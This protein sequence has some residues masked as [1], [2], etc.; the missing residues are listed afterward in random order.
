MLTDCAP[1]PNIPVT[2]GGKIMV[3]TSDLYFDSALIMNSSMQ[4]VNYAQKYAFLMA[5]AMKIGM[6][7]VTIYNS[8][9]I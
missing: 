1:V 6:I 8:S 5:D 3:Q 2:F 9:V 4:N 7:N